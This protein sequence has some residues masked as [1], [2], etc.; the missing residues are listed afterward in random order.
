LLQVAE[1]QRVFGGQLPVSFGEISSSVLCRRI[2]AVSFM[3]AL[4]FSAVEIHGDPR[5]AL[6]GLAITAA[7]VVIWL[8]SWQSH[9]GTV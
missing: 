9:A 7:V 3:S 8:G 6:V 1:D 4:L 5:Q 2:F